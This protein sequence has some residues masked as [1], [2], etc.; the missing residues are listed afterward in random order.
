MKQ[1]EADQ[2]VEAMDDKKIPVTYVLFPDEGHGF[3]AREPL[4]L[5]RDHR[6]LSGRAPRRPLNRSERVRRSGVHDSGR[7]TGHSGL[8]ESTG[9]GA[10]EIVSAEVD[11]WLL[12]IT[13][14]HSAT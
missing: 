6:G 14:T 2:I 7:R 13:V 1:A 8:G 9:S 3:A 12:F 10:L 5:L 4:R 11:S